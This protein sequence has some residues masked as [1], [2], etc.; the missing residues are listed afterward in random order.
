MA[1]PQTIP[2]QQ[3][4]QNLPQITKAKNGDEENIVMNL[5]DT[6]GKNLI[7]ELN[8]YRDNFLSQYEPKMRHHD[9]QHTVE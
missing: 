4:R 7:S 3:K 1:P 6:N 9:P 5:I 8:Q 2:A